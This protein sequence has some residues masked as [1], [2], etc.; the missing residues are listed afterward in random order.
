[1][2]AEDLCKGDGDLWRIFIDIKAKIDNKNACRRSYE[3]ISL[4]KLNYFS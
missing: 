2:A 4:I 3:K 1:M